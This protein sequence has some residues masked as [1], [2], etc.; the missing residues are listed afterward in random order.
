MEAIEFVK[1]IRAQVVEDDN[2]VYQN[3]LDTTTEAKDP[4]WRDILPIYKSMTKNQQV[5]F[6]QFLRMIQVNTVSH[7]LGILDGT[8][9]L[10]AN[11]EVFVLKTENNDDLLNG[12]LQD[13]FLGLEEL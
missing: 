3:L 1:E 2:R 11:S 13:V 7:I 8:T 9:T 5:V 12:Y 6:V 4:I 10:T